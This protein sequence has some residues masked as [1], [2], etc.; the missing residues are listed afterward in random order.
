M[1]VPT[2]ANFEMVLSFPAYLGKKQEV[3]QGTGNAVVPDGTKV[4]WRVNA[5]ATT[6]IQFSHNGAQQ[7]F[8]KDENSF[9]L[10][11]TILQ[12]PNTNTYQQQQG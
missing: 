4:T 12:I 11:K 7:A 9:T 3:V 8:I 2:I 1:A 6:G 5:V 10:S